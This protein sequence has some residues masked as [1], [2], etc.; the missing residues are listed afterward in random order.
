MCKSNCSSGSKDGF[1]LW[2]IFYKGNV[3][4]QCFNTVLQVESLKLNAT[5]MCNHYITIITFSSECTSL[6]WMNQFLTHFSHLLI[7]VTITR[8]WVIT[9]GQSVEFHW[10][11]LLYS[12]KRFS[13]FSNSLHSEC[14]EADAT[15]DLHERYEHQLM[16][17]RFYKPVKQQWPP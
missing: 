1:T 2:C 15:A 6:G 8:L 9:T 4:Q 17:L 14:K 12:P 7:T 11:H 13:K 3:I 5:K 10:V 16:G